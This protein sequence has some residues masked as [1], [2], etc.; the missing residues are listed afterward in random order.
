MSANTLSVTS[1]VH[2]NKT[3]N[4]RKIQEIYHNIWVL[5]FIL[6][7]GNKLQD[8]LW[9][10]LISCIRFPNQIVTEYFQSLLNWLKIQDA[11]SAAYK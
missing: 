7:H 5:Y 3:N 8:I 2:S 9:K 4:L 6:H 1:S 11:K 10:A